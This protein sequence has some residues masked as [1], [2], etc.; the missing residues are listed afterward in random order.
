MTALVVTGEARYHPAAL[1]ALIANLGLTDNPVLL[2]SDTHLFVAKR[3]VRAVQD[4]ME[5][6]PLA[7]FTL[8][9]QGPETVSIP[10]RRFT[11]TQV[12]DPRITSMMHPLPEEI[13]HPFSLA[14][15]DLHQKAVIDAHAPTDIIFAV[16]RE[17]RRAEILFGILDSAY[18][19][20]QPTDGVEFQVV[21]VPPGSPARVLFS[22]VLNPV[23]TV[24]DRSTQSATVTLPAAA[25]G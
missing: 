5:I 8:A 16:P 2:G 4:R 15:Y 22:R 23:S 13:V 18:T 24:S 3:L 9:D 17:A 10:R 7:N 12:P 14:V 20:G 6:S 19:G 11:L 1:R 25:A 21:L